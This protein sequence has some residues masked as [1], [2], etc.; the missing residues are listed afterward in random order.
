MGALLLGIGIMSQEDVQ[1]EIA[2][3]GAF[4]K[5]NRKSLINLLPPSMRECL[6]LSKNS[7]LN[8]LSPESIRK[9]ISHMDEYKTLRQL[10]ASFWKEYES[11]LVA[12]RGMYMT[13]VW[14]GITASSGQFY[15]MMK[16]EEFALYIFTKPIKQEMEE[17]FLLSLSMERME[18]ILNAQCVTDYKD[19]DT[20]KTYKVITDPK[21]AKVQLD[22][23]KHLDERVQGGVVKQVNVKS[24]QRS[25]NVNQNIETKTIHVNDFSK[26]DEINAQLVELR[27]K[28]K[29]IGYIVPLIEAIPD[30]EDDE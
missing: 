8:E 10:R 19:Q 15:S 29:E 14:Q 9:N 7:Q 21:G 6:E 26:M 22:L 18:D 5:E 28:T 23:Y 27:E 12:D 16:R 25:L 20:G 1:L 24:E 17:R 30:M 11:A 3:E 4:D 2:E 13:R